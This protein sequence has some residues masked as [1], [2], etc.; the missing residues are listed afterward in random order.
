[1]I[2]VPAQLYV[3]LNKRDDSDVPL[4]FAAPFGTDK[5]FEKRKET[6]DR[7]A[8]PSSRWIREQNAYVT[9]PAI[10]PLTIDN[11]P[12]E[13]FQISKSVR[14]T[15]WNGG[16]VVWRL[17]DPRGFELE[18]SS[19]NFAAIVNHCKMDK[20]LIKGKCVWGR[21]GAQNVLLP[22]GSEPYKE[23][24]KAT[25]RAAKRLKKGE[26]KPG[27]MV[28]LK[29]GRIVEYVGEFSVAVLVIEQN[30]RYSYLNGDKTTHTLEVRKR[31]VIK[32]QLSIH[33]KDHTS[34][35]IRDIKPGATIYEFVGALN[36]SSVVDTTESTQSAGE[37]AQTVLDWV[38]T[39][40]TF[41]LN[42]DERI[43]AIV[44]STKEMPKLARVDTTL[45]DILLGQTTATKRLYAFL[46]PDPDSS[47]KMFVDISTS[48]RGYGTGVTAKFD[49]NDNK[50][51]TYDDRDRS[52][53]NVDIATLRDHN[54]S[55]VVVKWCDKEYDLRYA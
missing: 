6:V 1:M 22:E 42:Y 5:A 29:D 45:E 24:F 23:A 34:Y 25:A 35:I 46:R 2:T 38:N 21:E 51:E 30:R 37:R 19:A 15:G 44:P 47:V 48:H 28:E 33:S 53:G 31:H 18:I 7:W 4:G 41:N 9:D 26:F 16:N 32:T 27:N 3:G 13:G 54:W 11:T 36:V 52:L 8:Q 50:W 20:G 17:E 12:S 49:L 43:I 40:S 55:K 10:D 39:S 14:R